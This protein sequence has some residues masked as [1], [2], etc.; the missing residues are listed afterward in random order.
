VII[1]DRKRERLEKFS[2]HKRKKSEDKNE[3]KLKPIK[4]RNKYKLN[5]ND[6]HDVQE[7]Q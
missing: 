2:R 5:I 3:A 4:K 7:L 6:L 1:N